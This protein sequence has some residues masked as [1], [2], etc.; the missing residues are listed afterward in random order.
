MTLLLQEVCNDRVER[1]QYL[2]LIK[3]S[4]LEIKIGGV[5]FKFHEIHSTVFFQSV[6]KK[7][8]NIRFSKTNDQG[9]PI[10]K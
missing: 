9:N 7:F 10:I 1:L 3:E 8:F 5:F 4:N 2:I 6:M